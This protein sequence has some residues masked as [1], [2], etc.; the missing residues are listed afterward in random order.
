[1]LFSYVFFDRAALGAIYA[2]F[3][4]VPAILFERGVMLPSLRQWTNSFSTPAY[5][6]AKIVIFTLLFTV[7]SKLAGMIIWTID[8]W[9]PRQSQ[10]FAPPF[11][12]WLYSMAVA[13]LLVSVL[14]VRELLGS[15]IFH[16]IIMARY[17][18]PVEEERVFLFVDVA[19]STAYAQRFGALAAASY[20]GNI[21]KLAAEPV[22]D[23]KGSVDDYIGDAAL[24]SWPLKRGMS[25]ARCLHCAFDI[26]AALEDNAE[27]SLK[28]FGQIPSARLILHAGPVVTAEVGVDHHKISYFGDTINL[29]GKLEA[30]IKGMETGIYATS[31]ILAG[32]AMPAYAEAIAVGD[33]EIKGMEGRVALH[34]LRRKPA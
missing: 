14:R 19:N 10:S 21:F 27:D 5:V 8:G 24:I 32:A 11:S 3:S 26:V 25:R 31:E 1:M 23:W 30:A 6:A 16:N 33:F 18:R 2:L 28:R 22:R 29:V 12:A 17:R 4:I 20:I 34:R 15:S 13:G 7:G 9:D